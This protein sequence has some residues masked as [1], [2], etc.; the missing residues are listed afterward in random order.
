MRYFPLLDFQYTVLLFFF[1]LAFLMLIW[2]AFAYEEREGEQN[3]R[4]EYP[5]GL[6]DGSGP[7][8]LL[9]IFLYLGFIIWAVAYVVVIGIQGH[10]F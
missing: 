5:D 9:L 2:L 1:G 10:P 8:P 6:R 7:V 3:I 4:E